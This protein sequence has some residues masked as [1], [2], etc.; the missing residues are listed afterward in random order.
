MT[1]F[2]TLPGDVVTN[3]RG[4]VQA[5]VALGLYATQADATAP[6][7]LLATVTTDA[8][9]RWSYTDPAR[10]VVWVRTPVGRVYA[11]V[12]PD[13]L[14]GT[15]TATSLGLGAV[16][17]TADVNKPVSTAQAAA[18]TAAKARANHTGSQLVA[19]VSDFPTATDARIDTKIA[20][21]TAALAALDAAWTAYTPAWTSTGTA[22]ALGNG[23]LTGSY[24]KV[25]SK[26]VFYKIRLT[27]GS[28]TTFG[29]G[30]YLLSLPAVAKSTAAY[31]NV[32]GVV[33]NIAN[34]RYSGAAAISSSTTVLLL[35]GSTLM[36]PTT[37]GVFAPA[38][39]NTVSVNGSYEAA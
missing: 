20:A 37:P 4:D 16:D 32:G 11:T 8:E 30:S 21:N 17:N 15:V 22:P 12:T 9:G 14:P 19:T 23:T 36:G 27:P 2:G 34:I 39:N 26:T 3:S 29:T 33:A 28:T 13:A 38:P 18:D 35:I 1:T 7:G 5:G 24:R 10:G 6:T 31:D 25:G